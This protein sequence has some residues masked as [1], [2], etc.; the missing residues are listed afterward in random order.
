M[1]DTWKTAKDKERDTHTNTHTKKKKPEQA[2]SGVLFP[3]TH[4]PPPSHHHPAPSFYRT[5]PRA[6]TGQRLVWYCPSNG[7]SPI[8]H[9]SPSP[10]FT[11]RDYYP[12]VAGTS[13]DVDLG[14][15]H[16]CFLLSP[17]PL[18]SCGLQPQVV[19]NGTLETTAYLGYCE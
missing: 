11:T 7:F 4:P 15:H 3:L 17:H 13:C 5:L 12:R 19:A 9:P 1:S 18:D 10:E 16:H 14:I 6:R 8:H 2:E